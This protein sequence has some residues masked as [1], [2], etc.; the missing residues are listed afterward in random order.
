MINPRC[1][2]RV[3]FVFDKHPIFA[4]YPQLPA[5]FG[6]EPGKPCRVFFTALLPTPDIQVS[7]EAY[8]EVMEGVIRQYE[9][10]NDNVIEDAQ[11][12]AVLK[13]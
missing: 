11:Y 12:N 5:F 2:L 10:L 7:D 1:C 3:R 8:A 9:A 13:V 4:A 6:Y